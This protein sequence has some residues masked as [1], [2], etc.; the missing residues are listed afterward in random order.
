MSSTVTVE[1]E[2][3]TSTSL[4]RTLKLPN[5]ARALEQMSHEY[6]VGGIN[7]LPVYLSSGK[8]SR[9]KVQHRGKEVGEE[10][11][12]LTDGPCFQR[13][14]SDGRELIDF[15]AGFSAC[16]LGQCHPKVLEAQVKCA[17]KSKPHSC[18]I[19]TTTTT[20]NN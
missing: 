6:S 20:F 18:A 15:I 5:S 1:S 10:D 2:A 4:K 8:G 14:D 17:Q 3:V 7:S 13:Q 11:E 19:S 12:M 16:N 9:V